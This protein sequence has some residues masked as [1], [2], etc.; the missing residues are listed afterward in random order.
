MTARRRRWP[1]A[2]LALAL[3]PSMAAAAPV[4]QSL[5]YTT[6]VAVELGATLVTPQTVAQET[7][8]GLVSLVPVGTY[9][10]GSGIVAYDR[11]GNGD[12]F[13]A[14]DVDLELPGGLIVR[15]GDVVRFDGATY[16]LAFDAAARGVP[17][18]A[19]VD[20]LR[21]LGAGKFLLS[22][23]TSVDFGSF[24]ADDEDIVQLDGAVATL[25]FD[26]SQHGVPDG[27]D[28]DAFDRLANGDLLLSFDT[29]GVIAGIAFNDEDVLAF[30]PATNA[31]SLVYA[32]AAQHARWAAAD[33][34]ALS[35]TLGGVAPPPPSIQ[36]SMPGPGGMGGSGGIASGAT[37]VFGVGAPHAQSDD[38]CLAIFAAGANGVPDQP[39]GSVD[40]ELLGTGSTDANGNFVD[41]SGL[42]GIPLNRPVTPNDLLFAADLCGGRVGGTASIRVPAPALAPP[43]LVLAFVV[44]VAVA[45]R[46]RQRW[47]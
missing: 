8:N 31:W 19:Q 44:L 11:A 16:A 27:L 4:L 17:S 10:A 47:A 21:V 37:R 29:S 42:P 25:F 45:W 20:A 5:R 41:A 14:F 28:L 18:G 7:A 23:D 1:L 38:A 39:P 40:D 43:A 24:V 6:D 34:S 9:P 30:T 13:L 33:L 35:A 32:G 15:P 2:L 26:G 46:R 3:V 12:Q 22:F 36:G